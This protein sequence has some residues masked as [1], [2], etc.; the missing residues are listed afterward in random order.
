MD[1]E[2][3]GAVIAVASLIALLLGFLAGEQY[4]L[5]ERQIINQEQIK[6]NCC[7][8]VLLRSILHDRT[9]NEI[10]KKAAREAKKALQRSKRPMAIK[11]GKE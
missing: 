3:K 11:E 6:C 9:E 1:N 10:N 8:S 4:G 2:T 7:H 5:K